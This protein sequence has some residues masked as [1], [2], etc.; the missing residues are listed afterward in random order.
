LRGVEDFG[1]VGAVGDGPAGALGEV[2]DF[3]R[4]VESAGVGAVV[5][6]VLACAGGACD[7]DC[8]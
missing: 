4:G 1:G 5:V 8:Q 2:V 3:E 7:G 6:D